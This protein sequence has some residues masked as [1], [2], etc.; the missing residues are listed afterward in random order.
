VR[1]SDLQWGF[2]RSL[3]S[4]LGGLEDTGVSDSLGLEFLTSEADARLACCGCFGWRMCTPVCVLGGT[5]WRCHAEV[6]W[7]Y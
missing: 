1:R 7:T 6:A 5:A 4:G 3:K 2:V